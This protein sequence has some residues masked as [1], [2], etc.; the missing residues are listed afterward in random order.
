MA[1]LDGALGS[2]LSGNIDGLSF[3]KRRGSDKTIVRKSSG[4][5]KDKVKNDSNLDL[6]RREGIEFGGR[7]KMSKYLM[8]ALAFQKPLADYNI[9]GP[10]TALMKPLQKLDAVSEYSERN[11]LLSAHPQFLKGFSMNKKHPFDNVIRYPV[12]AKLERE[13]LSAKVNFPELIPGINFVPPVNHPYYG[14]RVSLA[15]VPDIVYT[16]NGYAPVHPEYPEAC[17]VYVDSNWFSLLQ[18]SPAM[19]IALTHDCFPPDT[20]FTLVLAVGIR[21]GVLKGLNDIDQAPYVGS[22]KVLDVG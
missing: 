11:I 10:L 12:T 18:G 8:R 20:H 7:A 22:A 6:F 9:A 3:Y 14:F 16:A 5:T 1:T 4:H 19:E 15:I 21:Y 17:A 2:S 13:T